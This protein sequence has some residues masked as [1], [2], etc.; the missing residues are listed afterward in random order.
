MDW[1]LR[2]AALT[3]LICGMV[4]GAVVPTSMVAQD[5]RRLVCRTEGTNSVYELVT[6]EGF[7]P[8]RPWRIYVV[9]ATHT[10][11]GLHNSQY[12][13]RHG[14]IKRIEDAMRLV[15]A[16]TRADNDPAAYRYVIEGMWF[17]ENYPMDRGEA[18]A[19]NVISNYVHRGRIDIA[20]T[21]AGNH[22]HVYGPEEIRRSVLTKRRLLEKWG[23]DTR[24]MIMADNPGISWSI[25]KPY[26]E[27]GLSNVIFAPNQ[28]NPLPSTLRKMNRAIPVATWNPDARGGGN[29]IDVS[30]DSDRPMVF[31]WESYDRSTSLLVWCSTQYGH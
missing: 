8:A 13:Q 2:T 3:V 5:G 30:Y 17:W 25:V 23:V 1:I 15:D 16:D 20:A 28:W 24:T 19:W 6:D 26:A 27:A 22:T 21:C 10:D 7:A 12:I 18:A 31:K 14:T 29:Y 9:K 4:S 11:I